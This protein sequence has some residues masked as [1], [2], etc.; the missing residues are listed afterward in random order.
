MHH[1]HPRRTATH[2]QAPVLH[3]ALLQD[4]RAEH[5]GGQVDSDQPQ[6]GAAT[7]DLDQEHAGRASGGPRL[8][9][10]ILRPGGLGIA[11]EAWLGWSQILG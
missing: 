3:E 8:A 4:N 11:A 2:P 5:V 1:H 10:L 7:G 6:V 9:R